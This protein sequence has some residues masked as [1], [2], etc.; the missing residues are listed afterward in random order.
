MA[1]SLLIRHGKTEKVETYPED[2]GLCLLKDA[3]HLE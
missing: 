2:S 3:P 1:K